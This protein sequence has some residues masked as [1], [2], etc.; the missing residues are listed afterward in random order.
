M[1]AECNDKGIGRLLHAYELG[2]LSDQDRARV[3][4]HLI[5]C[6]I[7]FEEVCRNA[8]AA[9]LLRFD[10]ET[11]RQ[12]RE[13]TRESVSALSAPVRRRSLWRNPVPILIAVGLALVLVLK[14]WRIDIHPGDTVTADENRCAVLPFAQLTPSPEGT[15]LGDVVANLLITSL[16]QAS[17]M[18]IV[19]S[20]YL[21]DLSARAAASGETDSPGLP[22]ELA[23]QAHARWLL[24]G[25]ITQ[26]TPR[27]IVTAQLVE[28]STGSVA[29]AAEAGADGDSAVFLAVDQIATGILE[30]LRKRSPSPSRPIADIT[31]ASVEAYREYMLG[32]DANRKMYRAEAEQHFRRAV[33]LDS[34]FVIPRYHLSL[35]V[36]G[37]EGRACLEAAVRNVER[38][39]PRERYLI[40]SRDASRRNDPVRAIA[41]LDSLVKRYP[42]EKEPLLQMA[43]VKYGQGAYLEAVQ[44]LE[45]AIAL[46]SAYGQAYNQLAYSYDRLG[47]IDNAVKAINRY[48]ELS[49]GEANPYDS[50]GDIYARNGRIEPAIASYRAALEIKPD[51]YTPLSNLGMMYLYQGDYLRAESCFAAS[52]RSVRPAERASARLGLCYLP[53]YQG[54]FGRALVLIDSMIQVDRND[55]AAVGIAGKL[56]YKAIVYEAMGLPDSARASLIRSLDV[57][58]DAERASR[59]AHLVD[60]SLRC[61]RAEEARAWTDSLRTL[62]TTVDAPSSLYLRARGE[63]EAAAGDRAAIASFERAAGRSGAF[64]DRLRL[65][66][67]YLDFAQPEKAVPILERLTRTYT[68]GRQFWTPESVKL[69]YYLGCAYE[70]V[71]W[72]E[73]ASERYREFLTTWAGADEGIAVTVDATARLKRLTAQP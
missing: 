70:A 4:E 41:L 62:P 30:K 24:T 63:F 19:S 73:K 25:S 51:L 53:V 55:D 8:E 11:R 23:R 7:C 1:T 9:R 16:S 32:L 21:Y 5:V 58:S 45:A 44:N 17:S 68:V 6:D 61:D 28:I 35:L 64:S 37:D 43:L 69:N 65:A 27:L 59:M 38:A 72:R 18:Q 29:A 71:G 3:E 15:Q 54:R 34:N 14:D 10:P 33:E 42:D 2:L 56:W 50:R 48:I 40:L 22:T 52:E 47:D 36:P 49:P 39:G 12:V 31:T 46:D 57:S 66:R 67:A 26:T 13:I 60:I 20:Q